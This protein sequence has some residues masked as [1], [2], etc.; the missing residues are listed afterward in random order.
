MRAHGDP[1]QA[2]PT[3]DASGA[4]HVVDPVG[5]VG[6]IAGPTGH[7]STG[8]GV[9]CGRYLTAASTTL[10]GGKPLQAPDPAAGDKF[11]A[12]MRAHGVSNFPDPGAGHAGASP[13]STPNSKS[14]SFEKAATVCARKAPGG[15]SLGGSATLRAGQ[16]EIDNA[17]G[18]LRLIVI[19]ELPDG[20]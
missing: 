7:N 4:I 11:A 12:C 14:A 15:A 10:N 13:S 17:G 20:G 5:Y 1:N 6:T 19:G 16:I 2:E 9:I 3:I 18:A 8:A